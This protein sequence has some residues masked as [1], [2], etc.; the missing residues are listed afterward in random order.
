M[1]L[2]PTFDDL[3][4][5]LGEPRFLWTD[6]R[7]WTELETEL[8][9]RFPADYRRFADAYGAILIN[10]QLTIFHPAT[11]WYNLGQEIREEPELWEDIDEDRPPCTFGTGPGEVFPWAHSASSEKA[12]FRVPRDETDAWAVAVIERDEFVYTEYAMTFNAWMFAYLG[13]EDEDLAISAREFAPDGPFF[14]E[15]PQPG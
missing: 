12:Y 1:H 2:A 14:S 9:I 3:R 7:P 5:L 15:L 4:E 6:P 13:D 10:N 11:V 8:G